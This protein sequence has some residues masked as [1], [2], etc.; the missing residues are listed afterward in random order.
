MKK[1]KE[2]FVNK[3]YKLTKERAPLSF[4]LPTRNTKRYPLLW[5]DNETGQ[6]RALR[7]ARNQ[8]SPFEDEQD[9]NILLDPIVFEDGFLSVPKTNQ[10]LQKFLSLH[11]FNGT[12]FEEVNN[13]KDAAEELEFIAF[14]ADALI[15][16]R[17][18]SIEQ[19]ENLT[20][21]IFGKDTSKMTSSEIKRD[22]LV[23]AKTEPEEFLN[24]LED[25][26]VNLQ[27]Q[28]QTFF[29]EG[30]LI[31]KKKGAIHYNTKVNKKRMLTVPAGEDKL[32]IVT[33]F[34]Q[35]DEGIEALK[36]LEKLSENDEE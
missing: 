13:E 4:M 20:K 3:I 1:T 7:Y 35:S 36:L 10:A 24:I 33:S 29:D 23:F 15:A 18:L 17:E 12:Q 11:P 9:G 31:E 16:A 30:L 2:K 6:N 14:E 21:V 27:A 28:V 34:L 22:I 5:F 25:P 19:A 26:M 32:F 8:K